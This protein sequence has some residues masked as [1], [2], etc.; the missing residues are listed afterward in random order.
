MFLNIVFY[1]KC[2]ISTNSRQ[3]CNDY[4]EIEYNITCYCEYKQNST[5]FEISFAF[6]NKGRQRVTIG[7]RA[8]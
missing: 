3:N 2:I 4:I 1:H 5:V 7:R 6:R 8:W